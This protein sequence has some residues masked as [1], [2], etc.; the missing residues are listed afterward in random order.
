M[1]PGASRRRSLFRFIEAVV[2]NGACQDF[3]ESIDLSPMLELR[4]E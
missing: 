2:S 4:H 3:D 1:D